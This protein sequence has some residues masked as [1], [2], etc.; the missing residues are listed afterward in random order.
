MRVRREHF[1]VQ[2][3][4]RGHQPEQHRRVLAEVHAAVRSAPG[5]R[6]FDVG[7]VARSA[8]YPGAARNATASGAFQHVMPE[9]PS[10]S[11][12]TDTV[13]QQCKTLWFR[14]MDF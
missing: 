4:L 1:G 7:L 2:R 3:T 8:R 11:S 5:L 10:L 14:R 6:A 9:N 13:R 12:Q